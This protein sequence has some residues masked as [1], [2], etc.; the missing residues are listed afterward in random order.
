[1]W[2]PYKFLCSIFSK[3]TKPFDFMKYNI[4]PK[5]AYKVKHMFF[6]NWR[7]RFF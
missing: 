1:M 7:I 5:L 3:D 2:L 4:I 6:V